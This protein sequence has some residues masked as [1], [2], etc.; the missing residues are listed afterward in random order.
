MLS[1]AST[2]AIYMSKS[3]DRLNKL[4]DKYL[5]DHPPT[6]IEKLQKFE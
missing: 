3:D 5:T 2:L 1:L 4:E 6:R